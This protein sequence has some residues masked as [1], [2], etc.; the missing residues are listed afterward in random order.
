MAAGGG[1]RIYTLYNLNIHNVTDFPATTIGGNST[2]GAGKTLFLER[3]CFT[4]TDLL[5]KTGSGQT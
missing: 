2:V 1:E 4:E 5:T 3:D